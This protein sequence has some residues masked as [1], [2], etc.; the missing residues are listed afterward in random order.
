MKKITC[1]ATLVLVLLAGCGATAAPQKTAAEDSVTVVF[2]TD[3][4]YLSQSLTDNGE[5][6]MARMYNGDGKV[7]RYIDQIVDTFV[8]ELSQNPPDAVLLGG[9]LTL[10]GEKLSHVDLAKKLAPL[11]KQ[12]IPVLVIPGNHDIN[13][14]KASGFAENQRIFTDTVTKKE[15]VKLYG[16]LG[17]QN[18]L[19]KDTDSLS[20]IYPVR[21]DLWV[22]LLDVNE[23]VS[24]NRLSENTY[25]WLEG[26][27]KAAQAQGVTV[28]S[29]SHQNI[30]QHN[31]NFSSGYMI[32][33][34]QRLADLLQQYHVRLNL[35]GHIHVQHIAGESGGL[36]ELVTSSMAI[37]PNRYG[38]VTF[39]GST[40]NYTGK[41]MDVASWAK[42]TGAADPNLLD[43]S[44][45]S[46]QVFWD[47]AYNQSMTNLGDWGIDESHVEQMSRYYADINTSYFAGEKTT[48]TTQEP[49][50]ALW[51]RYEK[52]SRRFQY[53]TNMLQST[54]RDHA[55]LSIPI[56]K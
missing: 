37:A 30:L 15:F 13:N 40:L 56:I 4:H 5:G 27:L 48:H 33:D 50:F 36:Q 16:G 17:Y 41:D 47:I 44:A 46:R 9:D 45:Y 1:L 24:F 2:A 7:T 20:Y 18:A 51:E 28:L 32:D 22:L 8:A 53:I 3:L 6:F 10:D 21:S 55:T 52:D 29:V 54:V 11:Q 39:D 34:S 38:V 49:A 43:F 19:S 31:P 12:G 14:Y 25:T 35:T 42:T 23:S 26:Q